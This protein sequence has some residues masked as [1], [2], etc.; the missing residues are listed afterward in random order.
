MTLLKA[1][2]SFT[3]FYA[4]RCLCFVENKLLP[5]DLRSSVI[6]LS[7]EWQ[8]RSDVAARPFGP[9]LNGLLG[10]R[11]WDQWVGTEFPFHVAQIREE[12]RIHL[13]FGRGLK[14]LGIVPFL[15]L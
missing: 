3:A 13:Q 8:V 14:S 12:L 6:L 15:F 4:S 7:V 5:R 10:L 1:R 11:R 2:L 9:L